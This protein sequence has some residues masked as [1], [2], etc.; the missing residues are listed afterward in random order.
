[1][2]ARNRHG[3][4]LVTVV[5]PLEELGR[6]SD[7]LCRIEHFCNRFELFAMKI[8][9]DLH[10]ADVDQLRAIATSVVNQLVSLRQAAGKIGLALDVDGIWAERSLAS[11]LGQTDRIKDAL[12]D[13]IA[14]SSGLN[15]P[16]AI[17]CRDRLGSLTGKRGQDERWQCEK[18][19]QAA[20]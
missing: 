18:V 19:F 13:A 12:G 14:P 4:G 17:D 16:F 8:H 15:L 1:M 3:P 10:A 5:Q 2:V 20:T 11:R 7:V 6:I 9:V